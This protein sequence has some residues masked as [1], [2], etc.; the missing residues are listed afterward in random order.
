MNTTGVKQNQGGREGMGREEKGRE[1]KGRE[2]K[3]R[4]GREGKGREGKGS[5]F[6]DGY[7]SIAD[8]IFLSLVAVLSFSLACIDNWIL[9]SQ[10]EQSQKGTSHFT[11]PTS[12]RN[13]LVAAQVSVLPALRSG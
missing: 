2:G 3:G 11:L 5:Q 7:G 1:G 4:E 12:D 9:R 10:L 6:V 8:W 13:V